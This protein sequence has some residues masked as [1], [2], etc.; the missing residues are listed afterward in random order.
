VEQRSEESTTPKE[1]MIRKNN[2]DLR[3]CHTNQLVPQKT[4]AD[5]EKISKR[6]G[7]PCLQTRGAVHDG[8]DQQ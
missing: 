4:K 6:R 5:P 3:M 1:F 2:S 8:N 7:S